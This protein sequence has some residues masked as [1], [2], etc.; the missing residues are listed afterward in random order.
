L[1]FNSIILVL[2]ISLVMFIF[3]IGFQI[4][5]K[6]MPKKLSGLNVALILQ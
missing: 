2:F 3:L 6:S 4:Y 1:Y 5:N